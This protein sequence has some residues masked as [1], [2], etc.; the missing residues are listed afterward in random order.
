MKSPAFVAALLI[1]ATVASAQPR[2]YVTNERSGDISVIDAVTNSVTETIPV[3]KRP[4]GIRIRGDGKVLYVALSGSPIA[5]PGVD[6][7]K[8]PPPDKSADGIGVIDIERAALREKIESGSDPE[9]FSLS[10]DGRYLY[11]SN[12]DE[13]QV[14]VVDLQTRKIIAKLP[15][16]TEPEGVATSPDGKWVYVT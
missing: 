11:A 15:V 5:P 7:R 14:S 1:A 9:D 16:G 2:V 8:L 12:E 3:G 13:A 6:E 4:R 10:D